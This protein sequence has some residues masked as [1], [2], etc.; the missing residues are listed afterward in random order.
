[1]DGISTV[2]GIIASLIAVMQ[3]AAWIGL[4]FLCIL[5]CELPIYK[6]MSFQTWNDFQ[7][8][9]N[10][11]RKV[12]YFINL[13]FE[14]KSR[15]DIR[16]NDAGQFFLKKINTASDELFAAGKIHL[17]RMNVKMVLIRVFT[18]IVPV[19]AGIYSLSL[20]Y[21]GLCGVGNVIFLIAISKGLHSYVHSLGTI[22]KNLINSG[23]AL[24]N[25][26][27]V[28]FGGG[29]IL[30]DDI[31][32]N[33]ETGKVIDN[34]IKSIQFKNVS[35][36]YPD[37]QSWTIKDLSF[38]YEGNGILGIVGQ[39]G[40][41]KTTIVKL[42]L[43]LYDNYKGEILI[44]GVS[45]R[46]MS[47]E[48]K[49]KLF[50]VCFQDYI[51]PHLLLREALSISDIENINNDLLLTNV[52]NRIDGVGSL[53]N[54]LDGQLGMEYSGGIELSQ[55]Q[56][57]KLAVGRALIPNRGGLI[58]D[59]PLASLDVY[60]EKKY[61]EQLDNLKGSVS[62]LISH[63][64]RGLKKCDKILV[65]EEGRIIEEGSHEELMEKRGLYYRM[66]E[67]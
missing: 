15:R 49:N 3:S 2:I 6:R 45:L 51:C 50:S 19:A 9:D 55:G 27:D 4:L 64:M 44:N 22:Y 17:K 48:E 12:D 29:E 35:F 33:K 57:Q 13:F 28:I 60:S 34:R 25:S 63:R 62:I 5:L 67:V 61:Y 54:K 23:E 38:S 40:A 32:T 46:K 24:K 58:F 8:E 16:G 18:L 37:A 59:E 26:Y 56:W 41:G 52:I 21:Q 10:I 65:M 30:T 42:L 14:R 39:N 47:C 11:I 20:Y 53:E 31:S 1:M 7:Q 66:S 43:G 36:K